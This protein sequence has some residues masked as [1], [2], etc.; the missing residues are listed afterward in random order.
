MKLEADRDSLL[1]AAREAG[2]GFEEPARRRGRARQGSVLLVLTYGDYP[3]EALEQCVS[4]AQSL[5]ADLHVLQIL[6]PDYHVMPSVPDL[7]LIQATQ[8]VERCLAAARLTRTWCDV[9]LTSPLSAKRLRIR[10]GDFVE[11]AASRAAEVDAAFI[12]LAPSTGRLGAT[13]ADLARASSR[14]VL[15]ARTPIRRATL[16]AATDLKDD[17]Y[18]VLRQAAELGSRLEAPVVAVHNVSCLPTAFDRHAPRRLDSIH[19][20]ALR[21]VR[22]AKQLESSMETIV[23]TEVDPVDAILDQA[24]AH[25]ADIIVVGT[26]PGGGLSDRSVAAKVVSRSDRSVL[27]TPF[28]TKN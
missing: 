21:L 20:Q 26:R 23:A 18:W 5:E 16:L 2:R 14:P 9:V 15:V 22:A 10:I 17:Y 28:T 3:T 6:A 7:D 4:L 27:I 25:D 19:T 1:M 11:G 13:A 12:V 24:L 8:R